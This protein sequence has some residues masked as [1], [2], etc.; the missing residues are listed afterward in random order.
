MAISMAA[1]LLLMASQQGGGAGATISTSAHETGLRQS[2][3]TFVL[4]TLHAKAFSETPA[5]I[6]DFQPAGTAVPKTDI[7]ATAADS[8]QLRFGLAVYRSFNAAMYP[9]ISTDGGATWRIDG[10]QFWV[11]AAQAGNVTTNVRALGAHGAYFWGQG[12]NTVKVTND[13]GRH[14]W[15]TGFA[16][17]VYTVSASHGT[18]RTVA[19]GK[20][21]NGGPDF[22]AFLY[23]SEDSGHTWKLH[24]ELP[25]VKL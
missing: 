18:L 17:G 4:R 2:V 9:A 12:G 13:R 23:V 7:V 5:S 19:F 15:V 1:V 6:P 11:A 14:W 25:N 22:Q 20:Q 16:A 8:H 10:P 24:G 3:P 21:V